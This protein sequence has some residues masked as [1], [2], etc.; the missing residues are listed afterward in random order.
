MAVIVFNTLIYLFVMKKQGT[1]PVTAYITMS[2]AW[3]YGCYVLVFEPYKKYHLLLTS[4]FTTLADILLITVWIYATGGYQSPFYLLLYLSILTIALRYSFRV[5]LYA[6]LLYM[7]T[8]VAAFSSQV[9]EN[10][11]EISI[12]MIYLLLTA[13]AGGFLSSEAMDRIRD[14][15]II[16]KSAQQARLAEMKLRKILA[17][18]REQIRERRKAEQKLH[19]AHDVLE[20]NVQERTQDLQQEITER[21]KV[22]EQL[23]FK[24]REL[25]TFI[26]RATHDIRGPLSSLLGLVN[27]AKT[28][29]RNDRLLP[30]LEMMEKS[31]RRLDSILLDLLNVSLLKHGKLKYVPLNLEEQV[32]EIIQSVRNSTHGAGVD[33][34]LSV[35]PGEVF[36]NDKTLV[37]TILQN[38]IENSIKY[39]DMKTE[40]PYVAV[41]ITTLLPG[42]LELEVSDNGIGIP[43]HLQDKVFD[44]F[45]RGSIQAQGTGLGLYIVKNAVEK[46]EG[47]IDLKSIPGTGTTVTILLPDRKAFAQT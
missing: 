23:H 8:Y 19:E 37:Q 1:A 43:D 4:Y 39:R 41:K 2:L 47:R 6:A 35:K 16:E 34:R 3:L 44:M 21:K 10:Y 15:I 7:V 36:Y 42:V 18:L 45:F 5:T 9:E 30:H 24:I 22:E 33:F 28:E 31:V 13:I 40:Q 26:Y 12:R 17:R 38:L 14:K 20:L 29:N 11:V 32:K 27:L 25:D 46:L